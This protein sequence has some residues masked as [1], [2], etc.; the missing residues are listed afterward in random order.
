MYQEMLV[1]MTGAMMEDASATAKN[2]EETVKEI[3]SLK[4]ELNQVRTELNDYKFEQAVSDS[5]KDR[6]ENLKWLVTTVL[7]IAALIVSIIA[8]AR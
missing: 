4:A 5:N 2:T 3:A 1:G 7:S 6:V 8:I